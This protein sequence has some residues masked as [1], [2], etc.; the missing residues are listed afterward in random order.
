[1]GFSVSDGQSVITGDFS[2]LEKLIKGLKEKHS[3]EVGYFA[4]A[5][6][7]EGKQVAEYMATNEFGSI[8][9][10]IP[11]RSSIKMPLEVKIKKIQG[12]VY[13]KVKKHVEEGK[14]KAI[15][16][17]IGIACESVI[18]EAFDTR[19]FGTWAPNADKTIA[20]KGSDAPLID[21]GLARKSV[22]YRVK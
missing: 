8:I 21:E 3:V 6:T 22:T 19:G 9:K 13:S 12:Y 11:K 7:P 2:G 17:D 15:F 4:T 14:I 10:R 20:L 18:Q 16:E 1:M 5:K